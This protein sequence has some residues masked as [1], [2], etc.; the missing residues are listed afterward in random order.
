MMTE[1]ER[2]TG[3]KFPPGE[4]LHTEA[5]NAFLQRVLKKLGVECPPPTTNSR[6]IDKVWA[7]CDDYSQ[8]LLTKHRSSLENS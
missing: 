5:T 3:E 1:L 4:E 8:L 2:T 7:S 6:M